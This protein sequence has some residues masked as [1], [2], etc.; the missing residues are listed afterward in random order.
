[1][2]KNDDP[3]LVVFE[4]AGLRICG[5]HLKRTPGIPSSAINA[6]RER[7]QAWHECVLASEGGFEGSRAVLV[8]FSLEGRV[9]SIQTAHRTYTEG[10]ALR[11]VIRD[12]GLAPAEIDTRPQPE[13]SWG[14]S[15]AAYILL[16][17]TSVLCAQRAHALAVLPGRWTAQHSEVVEPSDIAAPSMLSL[18]ERLVTEEVP[19]LQGLGVLK[20]VGLTVRPRT[21]AWQLVGVLDLRNADI[22]QLN[23]ALDS[24][25]PDAETADWG[26]Y[27]FP[28]PDEEEA[29][30]FVEQL[31]KKLR[32]PEIFDLHDLAFARELYEKVAPQ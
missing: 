15:L 1:M 7:H 5:E 17:G 23:E 4:P 25:K 3:I 18:F 13:F 27:T 8:D 24:L 32:C 20:F 6:F 16:P 12:L 26:V 19:S 10:L 9:L 14:L 28:T 2:Q 21:H 31:P 29:H 30:G 11:D 22:D